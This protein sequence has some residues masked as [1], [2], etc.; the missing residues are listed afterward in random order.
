M[1]TWRIIYL[2]ERLTVCKLGGGGGNEYKVHKRFIKLIVDHFNVIVC[3]NTR[4]RERE[5]ERKR[6]NKLHTSKL[7]PQYR[8]A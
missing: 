6:D 8:D 2:G 7:Q 3:G 1:K 4:E 5:I